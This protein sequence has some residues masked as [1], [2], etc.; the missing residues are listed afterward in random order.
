MTLT[1][2][3]Y[4]V[5]SSSVIWAILVRILAIWISKRVRM[6]MQFLLGDW[7]RNQAPKM[8]LTVHGL[9]QTT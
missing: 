3:T 6:C 8:S 9:D 7:M 4:V 1:A 2:L 5:N